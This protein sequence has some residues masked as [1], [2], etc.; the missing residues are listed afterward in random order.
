M[1]DVEGYI[2]RTAPFFETEAF[3]EKETERKS[4]VFGNVAHVLSS[5]ASYRVE[6]GEPFQ[7]GSN[8]IQL[9]WDGAR[10]WIVSV[11]WNTERE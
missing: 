2:R 11:A 1:L 10:W 6:G 8:S 4:D 5:Y 7:R 9:V 3:W